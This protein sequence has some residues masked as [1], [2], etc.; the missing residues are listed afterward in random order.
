MFAQIALTEAKQ[1]DH[2][3]QGPAL[4]PERDPEVSNRV[5]VRL[6]NQRRRACHIIL[7][8]FRPVQIEFAQLYFV[9]K[10]VESPEQTQYRL[11]EHVVLALF[12]K[13]QYMDLV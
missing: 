6:E 1:Q 9:R 12:G 5:P 13:E 10:L 2:P 7:L 8:G 3:H 11:I 4:F